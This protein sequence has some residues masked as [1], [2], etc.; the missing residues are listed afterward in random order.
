MLKQFKN[1]KKTWTTIKGKKI[2]LWIADTY[3]KKRQG[4]SNVKKLPRDWGMLFVY[5]E[6]VDHGYTMKD[7][8]IPLTIIF[9]DKNMKVI[10][11]F[12]AKP[13]QISI[14]PSSPYRY[15][16]EI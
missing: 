8:K 9:L 4:L 12:F 5:T 14:K 10:E 13:G 3:Q 6:D 16:I 7:T 15:V 11:S 1:Y 2:N